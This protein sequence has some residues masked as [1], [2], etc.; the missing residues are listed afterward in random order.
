MSS[1]KPKKSKKYIPAFK[2]PVVLSLEFFIDYDKDVIAKLMEANNL[3]EDFTAFGAFNHKNDDLLTQ[4]LL[5]NLIDRNHKWYIR[6]VHDVVAAGSNEVFEIENTFNLPKMSFNE[7]REGSKI[8]IDRVHGIKS[9]WGGLYKETADLFKDKKYE[10]YQRLSSTGYVECR[11][12]FPNEAC[13]QEY[14][15]VKAGIEIALNNKNP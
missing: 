9:R 2:K 1:S 10:K 13:Y 11:T 15:R 7:L 12:A 4:C 3:G 14:L 6:I 5:M 8:T